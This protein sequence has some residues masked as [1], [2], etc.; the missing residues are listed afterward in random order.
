MIEPSNDKIV[1]L[2]EVLVEKTKSGKIVWE[3]EVALSLYRCEIPGFYWFELQR[4]YNGGQLQ[5]NFQFGQKHEGTI[6]SGSFPI[7]S[8]SGR[9]QVANELWSVVGLYQPQ[10][11]KKVQEALAALEKV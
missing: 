9:A 3:S 7:K 8:D 2:C 1:Q 4:V 6:H 10:T 11:D 5:T